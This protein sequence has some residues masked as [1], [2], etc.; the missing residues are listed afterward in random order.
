MAM[1]AR[2]AVAAANGSGATPETPRE[3]PKLALPSGVPA[4]AV[5]AV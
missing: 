5:A 4:R 2:R 1:A 3:G